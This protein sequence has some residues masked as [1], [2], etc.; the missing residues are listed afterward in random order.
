[1]G[2]MT[3]GA[4]QGYKNNGAFTPSTTIAQRYLLICIFI[5]KAGIIF[6]LTLTLHSACIRKIGVNLYIAPALHKA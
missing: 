2:A 3:S 4:S 5:H 1:M 6:N